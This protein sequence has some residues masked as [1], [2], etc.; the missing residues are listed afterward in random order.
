MNCDVLMTSEQTANDLIVSAD[1][2][3]TPSYQQIIY[4]HL[5]LSCCQWSYHD[6]VIIGIFCL[7]F[8]VAL[9]ACV[10]WYWYREQCDIYYMWKCTCVSDYV[11]IVGGIVDVVAQII[12]IVIII[13]VSNYY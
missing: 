11:A 6:N 3:S 1:S 5:S 13:P 7:T 10:C 2:R 4:L 9:D 8:L 12:H